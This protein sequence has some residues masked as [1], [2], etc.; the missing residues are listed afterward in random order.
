[1]RRRIL[2]GLAAVV[3]ALVVV[4]SLRPAEL[5][6]A[7]STMVAAPPPAVFAQVNDFK[8]WDAW[9]PYVKIDP[10]MKKTYAGAPTGMGAIYA[11]AGNSEAGEGRATIVESRPNELV[12]IQLDFLKPMEGNAVA[13][14]SFKPDG[15]K[16][17]VTWSFVGPCTFIGKAIGLF[18]DMDK[19]VGDQFEAGLADLKKVAETT[20]KS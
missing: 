18:I 16:T 11:W 9:S 17:Q 4:I 13:E 7:R 2:I 1:M 19:M 10:A 8:K 5:R 6:V 3:I 14:F 12:K 15:D 20:A